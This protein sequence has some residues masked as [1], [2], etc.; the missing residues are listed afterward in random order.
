VEVLRTWFGDF[1]NHDV[2]GVDTTEM[3]GRNHVSY[4]YRGERPEG[5]FVI[6]QQAYYDETNGQISW[7]RILCSGYR[8]AITDPRPNAASK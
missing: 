1:D 6:E 4:R 3:A 2:L 8:P 7:I 5:R